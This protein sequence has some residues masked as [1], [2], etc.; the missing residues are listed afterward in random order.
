MKIAFIGQKGLPSTHGGVERHVEE[1][2]SRLVQQGH[3]VVVFTRP[4]YTD[5]GVH[6]HKGMQLVSLPTIGSKHLDAIV[7]SLLCSI[8]VWGDRFD[9]VHYHAIGPCLVSPLARLRGRKVV[10]TVHGQDW[11]RGKWG[12]LASNVLRLGEWMALRV[13]N[14]TISVSETLSQRYLDEAG[15]D[16]HYV[17]NGISII[18]GDDTSI[19]REL[20]VS[21]GQYLLYAGRV[22]PEKGL[23]YLLE[24]HSSLPANMPLVIAGDTSYSDDYV[25]E[26]RALAGENVHWA[27]YVYGKRLAALFRHAALFVLPSD[28]EGLPIVLLEA[29]G[30]GVPVLASNIPPN[31]EVLGENGEL[32]AAGDAA[33][34][35]YRLEE[36]LN[37]RVEMRNRAKEL[38]DVARR[39]YDWDR[40]AQQ[41]VGVYKVAL[42]RRAS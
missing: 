14:A 33:N 12:F 7:H 17:P 32:F 42:G 28:L 35:R 23:H 31:V 21:D 3:E 27:G 4:N 15:K 38:R 1:L 37:H 2:G 13:P 6:E 25:G 26:V 34:L 5:P 22:V 36:C 24:A 18:D 19:L 10:A 20:G 11:R 9:I 30:Y 29:L 39:E 40:I 41:T 8:Y 16:T